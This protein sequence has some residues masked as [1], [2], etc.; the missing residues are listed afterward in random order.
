MRYRLMNVL[1]LASLSSCARAGLRSND[2]I[3]P[4]SSSLIVGADTLVLGQPLRHPALAGRTNGAN[5][6][7]R[8]TL[9]GFREIEVLRRGPARVASGDCGAG[10]EAVCQRRRRPPYATVEHDDPSVRHC[11]GQVC[12]HVRRAPGGI[13]GDGG[14]APDRYCGTTTRLVLRA[15]RVRLIGQP[16]R[17][18]LM[19]TPNQLRYGQAR[20]RNEPVPGRLRRPSGVCAK[21][22]ALPPLHRGGSGAGGQCVRSPH[23]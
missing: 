5:E 7:L 8:H 10:Q 6:V 3:A 14:D 23:V 4:L 22:H 12:A 2:A 13:I 20:V 19:R 11:P 16:Q 15:S 18:A 21:P 9:P 17:E 1:V